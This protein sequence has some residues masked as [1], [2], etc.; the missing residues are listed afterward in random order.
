MA[1]AG[2][3]A[4]VGAAFRKVTPKREWLMLGILLGSMFPDLDNYIVAVATV[5]KLNTQGLHRTFTHSILAILLAFASF[6][7]LGRVRQESRWTNFGIGFGAGIGLHILLDLVIWFNGVELLWPLGG[8][9]NLWEGIQP[10][11]WFAKLLDPAEFVFFALFLAWLAK[12]AQAYKTNSDFLG[13]LRRWMIV[14]IVLLVVFT[15]LAYIMN[16][17]FLTIYGIAY[18]F[19]ITATFVITIRMRQTV[20]ALRIS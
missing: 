4:L 11:N 8:W 14:I 2:L 15:P 10:P 20:E 9:V 12:T 7:I 16:K 3:H 5:A 17:G 1:Q 13:T 19:A 18:L 6:F